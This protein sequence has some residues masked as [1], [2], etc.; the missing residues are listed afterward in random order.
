[1]NDIFAVYKPKG[2]TSNAALNRLRHAAHTKK[3]GHAG[4]LDPLAEGVLVVGMGRDATKQLAKEVAKEKEYR[5]YIMLG[6]TSVTDDEEG[7][8]TNRANYTIPT[9][10]DIEM[11]LHKFEGVIFQIP[12]PYSAVK[13]KGKEAYKRVRKGEKVSLEPRRVEIKSITLESYE[14]PFLLLRVVT[15]PGV[16]IRSLARD[17]GEAL[18]TGGYLSGLVRTRVGQWTTENALSLAEAEARCVV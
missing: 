5:A 6:V 16:Y 11:I 14:W 8:K 18:G 7:E 15:G 10:E 13:V 12:P 1:M 17:M 4:T 2:L 3:I 9:R